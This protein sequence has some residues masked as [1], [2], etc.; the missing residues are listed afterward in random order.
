M[1]IRRAFHS[2]MKHLPH[3][4]HCFVLMFLW[5]TIFENWLFYLTSTRIEFNYLFVIEFLFNITVIRDY[6]LNDLNSL[7]LI[8]P[9]FKIQSMNNFDK[10]YKCI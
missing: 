3:P 2:G 6:V 5:R 4:N 7:K 8:K 9:C 1:I 10:H